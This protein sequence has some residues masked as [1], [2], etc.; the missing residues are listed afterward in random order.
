M[1]GFFTSRKNE[2]LELEGK[3]TILAPAELIFDLVN[4]ASPGNRLAARGFDFSERSEKL[5]H[6]AAMDPEMPDLRFEFDVDLYDDGKTYGYFSK[7][8][9][10]PEFGAFER[11][12]EEYHLEQL[13]GGRCR[14]TL[15]TKNWWREGVAG[16]DRRNEETVMTQAVGNDLARLKLEAET[17]A[18]EQ[19][20]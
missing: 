17:L 19:A 1:F 13:D 15:K 14:V 2:P 11:S 7:I 12:R 16:R 6:F 3:A 8:V 20:A 5:G 4:F 18:A 9:A 10:T